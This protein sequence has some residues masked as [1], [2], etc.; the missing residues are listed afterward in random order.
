MNEDLYAVLEK[1]NSKR[2]EPI[3]N[4]LLK[5]IIALVIRNPLI[6]DRARCQE[7]IHMIVKQSLGRDKK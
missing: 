5:Q 1:M 2:E 7:Q 3:D 6:E 4:E